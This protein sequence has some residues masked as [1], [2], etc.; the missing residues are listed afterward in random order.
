MNLN[1]HPIG[2][3]RS[4][5]F[6]ARNH[7]PIRMRFQKPLKALVTGEGGFTL[8]ASTGFKLIHHF[9]RSFKTIHL[10]ENF[11]QSSTVFADTGSVVDE[12]QNL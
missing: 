11:V 3:F 6:E 4:E 5:P 1:G 2:Q 8:S 10:R 9:R 12:A 7:I